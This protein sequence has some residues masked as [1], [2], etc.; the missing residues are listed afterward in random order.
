MHNSLVIIELS[1]L[2]EIP[3]SDFFSQ[4]NSLKKYSLE[5]AIFK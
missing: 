2:T 4:I 3:N 5:N 1:F